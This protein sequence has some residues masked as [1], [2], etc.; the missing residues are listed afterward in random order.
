VNRRVIAS[1]G[2]TA[3]VCLLLAACSSSKTASPAATS[4]S[5]ATTASSASASAASAPASTSA[6]AAS[7]PA[8]PAAGKVTLTYWSGFTGGDGPTYVALV[9][10]FNAT[11]PNIQV[12]MVVQPWDTIAQ[13]LPT[14]LKTGSGP[15][16]ATPDYNVGT[17]RNYIT[18]GLIAPIDDLIGS[19][20]NQIAPGV[21]PK[22]LTD[23]FTVNGHLYAAPANFATLL[24][25]Y[26]KTLFSAAGI[27]A[28]PTTMDALR[29]DAVKLTK[30]GSQYGISLA[31]NNT[32]AMWPIL[33]WADGGDIINSNNCSALDTPATINAV[34]SWASLIAKDG[35][36][37]VGQ[38]GQGADNLFTANKAAMEI[39]GPWAT[40]EYN[41]KVNYDVAPVPVGSSGKEITLASTVPM[42][43][44][45]TTKHKAEALTFFA[46]WLS[47]T[48][49]EGLAKGSGY[50]PSRTDMGSD[51]ALAVNPFVPKFAAQADAARLYLPDQPQ[52][53][54]IDT[55]IFSTA[56]DKATRGSNVTGVLTSAS[57]QINQVT[58]C[59][60]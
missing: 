28:P 29:A 40:G 16:I 39:N 25:Y 11:H 14:A 53:A 57:S 56:I 19:G 49:Q 46:W 15:D 18:D 17:I 8:S 9:K 33:I 43:V 44:S 55:D 6:A 45:A 52:F 47:K 48:A 58:G 7:T 42:V 23:G 2:T 13:K 3:S 36:S 5:A 31:D 26:N 1:I 12:N 21:L 10:E 54:Q 32:I 27:S 50:P 35:I 38:T 30:K 60:S 51:P 22:T 24:L 37:P 59:K 4:S 20:L 41:G 34:S